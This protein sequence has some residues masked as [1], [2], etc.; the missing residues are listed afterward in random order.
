VIRDSAWNI[1]IVAV[2]L[3]G[4]SGEQRL[5]ISTQRSNHNK[6]SS[7]DCTLTF[8]AEGWNS[9]HL[10][11]VAGPVAP[12]FRME[13]PPLPD[14]TE[15][16]VRI[17]C[18]S[19]WDVD[20][21]PD[22]DS[23]RIVLA[24]QND[25]VSGGVDTVSGVAMAA[26]V[27]LAMWVLG[28]IRPRSG[29]EDAVGSRGAGAA[30]GAGAVTAAGGVGAGAGAVSAASKD[31]FGVSKSTDDDS[32]T[33]GAGGSTAAA[34]PD[35]SSGGSVAKTYKDGLL[36]RASG[37][38]KSSAGSLIEEDE[39]TSS[40]ELDDASGIGSGSDSELAS[41]PYDGADSGTVIDEEEAEFHRLLAATEDDFERRLLLLRY[42]RKRR[43]GR[44]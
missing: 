15:I 9:T 27:L 3:E 5:S 42:N 36:N 6:L 43:G 41:V 1:G 14:G 13:R 31:A 37:S 22:D 24:G 29:R 11:D 28:I 2:E 35:I 7:S 34:S 8:S 32:M 10:I 44:S 33:L 16:D 38:A 20:S 26:I 19:P 39:V 18:A 23:K 21:N 4:S 17:A 40:D 12:K 25:L 30:V